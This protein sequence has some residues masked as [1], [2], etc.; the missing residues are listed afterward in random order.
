MF[1]KGHV[2]ANSVNFKKFSISSIK[3]STFLIYLIIIEFFISCFLL[4]I[5]IYNNSKR[6]EHINALKMNQI[7]HDEQVKQQ[8][9]MSVLKVI[10]FKVILLENM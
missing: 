1:F 7:Y 2:T 6:N 3:F 8:E 4:F 9:Q 10:I 5:I